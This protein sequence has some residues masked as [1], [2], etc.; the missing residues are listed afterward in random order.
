[1][2]VLCGGTLGQVAKFPTTCGKVTDL[3]KTAP[4]HLAELLIQSIRK[5]D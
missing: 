1:M 3:I 2:E 4:L 5:R